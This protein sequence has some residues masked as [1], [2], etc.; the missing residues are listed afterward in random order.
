MK[1]SIISFFL[2]FTIAS[3]FFFTINTNPAYA[4]SEPETAAAYLAESGILEGDADGRL[5]L[6]KGLTRAELAVIL[7]R[8]DF[9]SNTP[10]GLDEWR[11]WG[12]AHYSD[13]ENRI[14]PFT[15][16]PA[17]ALPYTEYCYELS[18]MKGVGDNRFDPD[19]MVS[20]KM[21]CTV[22]LRYCRVPETDWN[23]ETSV[24]KAQ[25]LGLAPID[26]V[27]GETHHR[28]AM[29]VIVRRG[30]EYAKS[31]VLTS[32]T[33][34]PASLPQSHPRTETAASQQATSIPSATQNVAPTTPTPPVLSA[35]PAAPEPEIV[36]M[37]IEEMRLEIVRLTNEERA[38][39]GLHALEILPELMESAQLKSDD[40][41]ANE[42]YSHDSPVYGTAG[43]MIFRFVPNAS[44]AA[45]NIARWSMTPEEVFMLW[46]DSAGHKEQILS[47]K[48][49]HIGVG[50]TECAN[51]GYRWV[52]QFVTLG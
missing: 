11:N 22:M 16:V 36:K 41:R 44:Y 9:L 47:E 2:S 34:E 25:N 21:A 37:T 15:D 43:D 19:G 28:G 6:D 12:V 5:N 4:A 32:N 45:E 1:H 48:L 42:Y 46:M 30:V 10:D 8:L 27:N 3:T 23:Y 39:A 17:W 29:A 50:T 7:T 35:P 38:K 18:L 49:T 24:A 51:G 31:D 13:P 40:M 20:P 14:N 52:Q 26:G 33:V